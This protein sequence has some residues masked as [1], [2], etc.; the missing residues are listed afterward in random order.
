MSYVGRLAHLPVRLSRG[1]MLTDSSVRVGRAMAMELNSHARPRALRQIE[2]HSA[3]H[4]L[5]SDN[6]FFKQCMEGI[7][8]LLKLCVVH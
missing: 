6:S 4:D 8:I 7:K 2:E 5:G 1:R 3:M